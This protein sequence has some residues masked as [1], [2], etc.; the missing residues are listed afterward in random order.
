MNHY[1]FQTAA[2]EARIRANT[3]ASLAAY[4]RSQK[5]LAGGVS[6]GRSQSPLTKVLLPD[7]D[8][9]NSAAA[10]PKALVTGGRNRPML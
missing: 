3:P 8:V 2:R 7:S 6:T 5:S 10:K 9:T 1:D 4:E